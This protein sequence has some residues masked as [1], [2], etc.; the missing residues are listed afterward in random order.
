VDHQ[1]LTDRTFEARCEA[2]GLWGAVDADVLTH[3][4]NP[5]FR[6]G[7]AWPNVR[8]AYVVARRPQAVLLASDGLSDPFSDDDADQDA[9][10]RPGVL[11]R[12]LGRGRAEAPP[13]ANGLR[14]EFYAV[15]GDPL[16]EIAGS[17]LWDLVWQ[18]SNNAAQHGRIAD[19]IGELG[20]L[21]MELYDVGIPATHAHRF[22]RD[23]RVGVLLGLVDGVEQVPPAVVDGPLSQIRLV[24]VK[25]LTLSELDHVI[26]HGAE[27]RHDLARRFAAQ[28]SPLM[29]SL[30]RPAVG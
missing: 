14:H 24:N 17:W 12:L 10:P 11:G 27:G 8:Q 15:T 5:M 22:V 29:S 19:V 6:G 7:P 25:L 13:R 21:S 30:D 9:A 1:D 18:I 20:Y 26:E 16:D 23:D 2:W 28:G 3:L 4:I